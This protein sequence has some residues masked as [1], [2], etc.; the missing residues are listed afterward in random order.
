MRLLVFVTTALLIGLTGLC[1]SVHGSPGDSKDDE[2]IFLG[3]VAGKPKN[4]DF[5]LYTHLCHAFVVANK[6][7][8]LI[9]RDNVPDRKLVRDAHG[10]G[11][12]VLISLGGW[13]WDE[14]FQAMSMDQSAE[15][16]YVNAV[17]SI[18]DEYDYDGIDLD[19]EYPDS[20]ID[21]VGFERLSRRFRKLLD[22]LGSRENRSMELTMAAAA[23]PKTLQ[24]LSKDFLLETMDWVNVM[25]YDY[26]GGWA[27]FA[28]HHAPLFISTKMPTNNVLSSEMTMRYL[29]E[30]RGIPA[31]RLALGIPLYGRVFAVATPYASTVGASKPSKATFNFRVIRQLQNEQGWTRIWD[32]ETKNPWLIAPDKSE[33]VCYDDA[34][35]VSLKTDWATK[36]GFRGVFFWQIAADRMPDG[37][38][39]MQKAAHVR[40]F[41]E[42]S[43]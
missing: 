18:V 39:P 9:S 37:T 24:W 6:D 34:Q 2:K 40:L 20:N 29:V 17:M 10:A 43:D 5:S 21:I 30:E 14:N 7:G 41:H 15:D 13:G 25:T 35:S 22:E 26:V 23:H 28:G 32:D 16:R 36:Q 11:V 4:I 19:W 8:T 38:N 1:E 27:D 12:R 31:N 33:I 3:Y 42:A